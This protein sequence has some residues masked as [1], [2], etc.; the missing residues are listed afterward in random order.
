VQAAAH[1]DGL[2]RDDSERAAVVECESEI[3]AARSAHQLPRGNRKE[4]RKVE[5]GTV[6]ISHRVRSLSNHGH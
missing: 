3:S 2:A 6:V 5:C 4:F 1:R